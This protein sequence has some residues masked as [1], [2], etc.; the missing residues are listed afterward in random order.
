MPQ[1]YNIT[2]PEGNAFALIGTAR[3]VAQQLDWPEKEIKELVDNM[4]SGSYH[5]LLAVFN[6]NFG[7]YYTLIN[8]EGS[9]F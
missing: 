3:S 4:M 8:D 5:N 1:E 9:I 7:D 6:D 2:G